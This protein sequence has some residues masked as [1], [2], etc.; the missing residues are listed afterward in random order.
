MRAPVMRAPSWLGGILAALAATTAGAQPVLDDEALSVELVTDEL[1][2]PASLAFIGGDDFLVIQKNDGQVMRVTGGS[3]SGPVLDLPVNSAG[4]R[5]GL[6]IAAHR[7]FGAG[8][9]RDWVYVY[10]TESGVAGDVDTGAGAFANQVVRYEWDGNALVDPAPILT[11]PGADS[12]HN[13][14]SLVFGAD[15]MLYGV[16]G[17]NQRDGQLQNNASG[18]AP[19]DTGM[20]FR[21]DE[22]GA[23]PADNPFFALGGNLQKVFAYGVR[24]SFGLGFDPLSGGLWD[25]ENG[26]G[27]FDEVNRV[28][29]GM[30]SGWRDVMGPGMPAGLVEFAGSTY[31][32][33]A[34]SIQ[35]PVAVTGIAFAS[36]ATALG[37]DYVGDAFVGDFNQGQVYRFPVNPARDGLALG[38]LVANDQAE[39]DGFR[40]ASGFGGGVTDLEEGPDGMLY[41]VEIFGGA[42][43]RIGAAAHD[44]AVTK[45]KTPRRVSLSAARPVATKKGSLQIRNVGTSEETIA[46]ANAL[47]AMLGLAIT[48]TS[49]ACLAPAVEWVPPKKGFPLVV[50]PKKKLKL[51]FLVSWDC[52]GGF[53]TTFTVSLP[54][55]VDPSDDVCPRPRAG[56]DKGCGRKPLGSPLTTDVIQK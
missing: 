30:N 37:D 24:N 12:T 3:V 25:T 21:V 31:R 54:E 35:N 8:M 44:F 15:G 27:S 7:D 56:E 17:D 28:V 33:P 9:D 22:N 47:A 13:G 11:L 40:L 26:P 42:V 39:L 41:V 52:A 34:Y 10:Y 20:I 48:P 5:G 4:E 45:L 46:D 53:E 49:E 50:R 23:A 1:A 51:K 55:D 38:D 16:I 18:A 43:Y 29:P 14:G 2:T 6:G 36:E 19:D 32:D